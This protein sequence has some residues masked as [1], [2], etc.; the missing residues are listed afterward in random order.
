MG[1]KVGQSQ[2]T[3]QDRNP[4]QVPPPL[5]AGISCSVVKVSRKAENLQSVKLD[6]S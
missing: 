2:P 5:G 1:V 3:Y 4:G 6:W